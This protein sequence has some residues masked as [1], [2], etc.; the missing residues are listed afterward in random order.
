MISS[1]HSRKWAFSTRWVGSGRGAGW[2]YFV[3]SPVF[4]LPRRSYQPRVKYNWVGCIYSTCLQVLQVDLLS[5]DWLQ[6]GW[7]HLFYMPTGPTGGPTLIRLV[8]IGLVALILHAYRSYRWAYSHQTGYNWVGCTYS[9][10]LQV[11]QVGLLSS[12]WLQ[13][14]WLHLFY[15]PTGPTGGLTLIRL[16]TIGLAALILHAYRSY[17]WTYSHQT[18]YNWVGCTYSTCLQVLQ[19]GLPSSDWLQLGWLHLFYMPTGPTG[20]S[21]LIRLVTIG[22]AALILHAYRSYRWAYSHQTG[23]NWVGCTYSACIKALQVGLLSS[24][25]L[26]LGW[27]HL[28]YMPT[29]PTG[30][31]TLI[32]LV[33]IGLVALILH[34]YR[35]YRWA[36]SHQ[37]GVL[38]ANLC[39]TM[40]L[41]KYTELYQYISQK[42]TPTKFDNG[43]KSFS[44][45][46][47]F[48]SQGVRDHWLAQDMH[49]QQQE[50]CPESELWA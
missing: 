33:T 5:S 20:G 1:P 31:P 24:D 3:K 12:D 16:V 8:T 27:L 18:G 4:V 44:N 28:F 11:L 19:V 10:C 43:H 41:W 42:Y 26:Q 47:T 38:E 13:L 37:T 7:L 46:K 48:T 49:C 50:S 25:W 2:P 22:L 36:Y 14:G 15:M 21:T 30:G 35:S 23:Y 45:I 39:S 34:A 17:R 29:G 9:P 40:F 32:R 6:L